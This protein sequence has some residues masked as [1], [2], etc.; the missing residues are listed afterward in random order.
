MLEFVIGR[1]KSGK[2]NLLFKKIQTLA[3]QGQKIILIVPLQFSFET[4]KTIYK[5]LG[6]KLARQVEVLSFD[7]L[8]EKIF[9]KYGRTGKPYADDVEKA[10]LLQLAMEEVSDALAVYGKNISS[11]GFR[12]EIFN[13]ISQLKN[14]SVNCADLEQASTKIDNTITSQKLEDISLI[15]TSYCALLQERFADNM[16]NVTLACEL[17]VGKDYFNDTYVFVDGFTNFM[18]CQYMMLSQILKSATET[19]VSLSM[20]DNFNAER[21]DHFY[22]VRKTYNKLL[23]LA[24]QSNVKTNVTIVQKDDDYKRSETLAHLE[25]NLFKNRI[26]GTKNWD[27][28]AVSVISAQNEY[29]EVEYVAAT[30]SSLVKQ[31]YKYNDILVTARDL[32]T[33]KSIIQTEFEKYEIPAFVSDGKGIST[34][35][36]IKFSDI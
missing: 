11:Q 4:E 35:P 31:G 16:D 14:S 17:I 29:D 13:V 15:Y 27:K 19:Y 5:K 30:I 32:D 2:T 9:T 26:E 3:N 21:I 10:I 12:T 36:I 20:D 24:Q 22:G 6:A 8:S 1:A 23:A 7:R 25:Q 28:D 34:H 33:Y 18:A